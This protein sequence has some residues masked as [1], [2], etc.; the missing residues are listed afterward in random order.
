MLLRPES[1]QEART[2]ATGA[3]HV[4]LRRPARRG[5][6]HA[7]GRA[8]AA[9]ARRR[10]A[11][12]G[13]LGHQHR[14]VLY[15]IYRYACRDDTF[16]LTENP[17]AKT[18]KRR[19]ADPAEIVTYT[20]AEVEAIARAAAGRSAPR[21]PPA[22]DAGGIEAA[23]A[24]GRAGRLLILVA[25]FCGLR[26]GGV[27]GVALAARHVG[28]AAPA[29]PAQ[30]RPR[31]GGQPEGPARTQRASGRPARAGPRAALP[32][33]RCSRAPAISSSAR[34]RG[35]HLDA[36]ALQPPLQGRT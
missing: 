25:A 26:Y 29:C 3:D 12:F 30:L 7:R 36:S 6:H 8:V 18:E 31:R 11:A 23:R 13:A 15:S 1:A 14:Q 19:E 9:R 5:D 4:A 27:P 22:A 16:G 28:R 17:A 33:P 24:G 10:P 32:A 20:P 34:V 21:Q 35:E 2:G